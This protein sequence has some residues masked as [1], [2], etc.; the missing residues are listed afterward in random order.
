MDGEA[1]CFSDRFE[2]GRALAELL[3]HHRGSGEVVLGLARGG[4]PVAHEV[5]RALDLPPS[6]PWGRSH[7]ARWC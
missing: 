1:R 3:E 6:W 5:A 2:A 4:V 7:A